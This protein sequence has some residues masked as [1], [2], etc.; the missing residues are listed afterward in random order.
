MDRQDGGINYISAEIKEVQKQWVDIYLR[1]DESKLWNKI[2]ETEKLMG[3]WKF[4][5]SEL[6]WQIQLKF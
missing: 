5:D 2:R 6:V 1:D 3:S 4:T